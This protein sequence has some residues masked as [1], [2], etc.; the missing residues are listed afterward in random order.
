MV[1]RLIPSTTNCLIIPNPKSDP[2]IRF[3]FFALV[4]CS[5]CGIG[6]GDSHRSQS[7]KDQ[8]LRFAVTD[9]EGM[10]QLQFEFGAFRDL[11]QEKTGYELKFFPVSSRTAAAEALAHERVDLVLTGPAEYV[12]L[13][14]RTAVKPVIGLVRADYYSVFMV[15]ESSSVESLE[16]LRGKKVAMGDIGSTS[17]HLAPVAMLAEVGI[18]ANEDVEI[19]HVPIRTG[20]EM[21]QRGKVDAFATTSDKMLLLRARQD[22]KPV[23][24]IKKSGQLPNDVLLARED[25]DEIVIDNIRSAISDS[26]DEFLAAILKGT[27][28]QKYR[29][30]RFDVRAEDGDYDVVRQMFAQAGLQQFAASKTP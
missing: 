23:R 26:G 27:D 6:G 17:K 7:L 30:M 3:L 24:V 9:I 21:L 19:L 4:F 8:P 5:G 16:D 25:I 20:W 29:E 22:A 11:L 13:Q 15:V 1:S 12:M 28:N 2:V 18:E 10:E 14:T